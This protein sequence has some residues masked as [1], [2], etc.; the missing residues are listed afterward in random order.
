[1]PI[2]RDWETKTANTDYLTQTDADNLRELFFS[3]DVFIQ[4]GT[5]WLPVVITSANITEKTNPRTQKLYRYTVEY[6]L[7][8]EV[9]ARR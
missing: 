2:D 8:N 5:E 7:A 1:M 4:D 6:R 3:T 9:R